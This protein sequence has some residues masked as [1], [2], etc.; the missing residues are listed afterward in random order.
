MASI[1]VIRN[2]S[3]TLMLALGM[4]PVQAQTLPVDPSRLTVLAA[5]VLAQVGPLATAPISVGY[6]AL[7][8]TLETLAPSLDPL[9]PLLVP[10]YAVTSPPL[11]GP[12][13]QP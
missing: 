9:D 2:L 7:M 4:T 10:V 5:P 1:N 13:F 8:E 3:A 12:I 11:V 6:P